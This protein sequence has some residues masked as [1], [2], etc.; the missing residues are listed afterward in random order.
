MRTCFFH[1]ERP[2]VGICMRCRTAV[3]AACC[4][5]LEGINHC[6]A[7]L[8]ALGAKPEERGG[9]IGWATVIAALLLGVS[10]LV[11]FGLCVAIGGR[12]AP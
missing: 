10:W 9:G 8:K 3:C 4:T 7:C 2:A 12:M 6:H 5:R 1:G 11:L